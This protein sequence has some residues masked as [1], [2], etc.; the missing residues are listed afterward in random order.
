MHA[1]AVKPG[2]AELKG[3]R[4]SWIWDAA[5]KAMP[6]VAPSVASEVQGQQADTRYLPGDGRANGQVL[7]FLFLYFLKT[8]FLLSMLGHFH[9]REK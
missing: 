4:Q 7:F 1:D 8:F 5:A 9:S 3:E 2:R 6:R